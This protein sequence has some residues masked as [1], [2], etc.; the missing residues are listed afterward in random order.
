[1]KKSA[2]KLQKGFTLIE[3]ILVIGIIAIV[4]VFGFASIG[5]LT[6]SQ[7]FDTSVDDFINL[8]YEAKS[9][10]LSQVKVGG[11]CAA[12]DLMGY[13]I[14]VNNASIPST[15]TMSIVCGTSID[16]PAGWTATSVKTGNFS[17]EMSVDIVPATSF[18]F[19]VPNALVTDEV[20]I[21]LNYQDQNRGITIATTGAIFQ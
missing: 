10:T 4:S 1:M 2:K 12:T 7:D 18:I 3:L 5:Q 11:N 9:N 13:K 15:Y 21:N 19:E 16:I 20:T 17:N 8:V 6:G 14:A